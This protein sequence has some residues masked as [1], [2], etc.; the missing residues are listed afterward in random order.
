[1]PDRLDESDSDTES[2]PESILPQKS[3]QFDLTPRGPSREASPEKDG[4][5]REGHGRRRKDDER[6]DGTRETGRRRK[7]RH[8]DDEG[9]DSDSTLDLP[10]RFDEQGYKRSEDP[11]ADKLES[12]LAGLF[13]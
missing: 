8:R 11:M 1:M 13:R 4:A 9:E 7:R 3:V 5:E 12:L 2:D 10:P 6:S